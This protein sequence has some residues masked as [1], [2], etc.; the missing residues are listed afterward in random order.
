MLDL[1]VRTLQGSCLVRSLHPNLTIEELKKILHETV[2]HDHLDIPKPECQNLVY[3][4]NS[5][6]DGRLK[7]FGIQSG[8]S[9]VLIEIA[10]V[11]SKEPPSASEVP[12]AESIAEA[13]T[14][15]AKSIGMEDKLN[16]REEPRS[17]RSRRS[18]ASFGYDQLRSIIDAL[19]GRF[20]RQGAGPEEGVAEPQEDQPEEGEGENAFHVP[21]PNP[22]LVRSLDGMGFSEEPVRKALLLHRNG[23]E[24]ALDWL[25]EHGADPDAA[26]PLTQ[27]QL[28]QIYGRRPRRRR[29]QEA[30]PEL[31]TRLQEMGFS[32]QHATNAL[33]TF[34]NN[35]E[36]AI[37]WLL[38]HQGQ[39]PSTA[40]PDGE[41]VEAPLEQEGSSGA[42]E[43]ANNE[44]AAVQDDPGTGQAAETSTREEPGE[45][46][47]DVDEEPSSPHTRFWSNL[48]N[49]G[50]ETDSETAQSPTSPDAVEGS[51]EPEPEV[52]VPEDVDMVHVDGNRLEEVLDDE[53]FDEEDDVLGV[54][55]QEGELGGLD[56]EDVERLLGEGEEGTQRFIPRLQRLA[57][58]DGIGQEQLSRVADGFRVLVNH[59]GALEEAM[60]NPN[61]VDRLRDVLNMLGV[62]EEAV[63]VP[64][65]QGDEP[66]PSGPAPE[67]AP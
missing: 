54:D 34:G 14:V 60:H 16:V 43:E 30:D 22:E 3:G 59:P 25:L 4:G 39:D 33:R 28:A 48:P 64:P 10:D 15:Y 20:V 19:E 7:D 29:T 66:G 8:E 37:S 35:I 17:R 57:G 6:E 26:T 36:I 67:P 24:A 32:E 2:E 46:M 65:P 38:R 23:L 41:G 63:Q 13:I 51:V 42:Q 61:F 55:F 47:M 56:L 21:E 45:D 5:L 40:S 53:G 44:S 11:Q 50:A 1:V 27:E 12:T 18:A 31:I 58:M 49:M 52:E 9:V 62:Q